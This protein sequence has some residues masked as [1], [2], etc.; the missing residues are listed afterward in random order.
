MDPYTIGALL[1]LTGPVTVAG[2]TEG[3]STELTADNVVDYLLR[4]EYRADDFQPGG[5]R[6]ERLGAAGEA[7]FDRLTS[8][9]LPPPRRLADLLSP[10]VHARR[11]LFATTDPAPHDLLERI[12]LWP[13]I[14]RGDDDTVLV[15]HGNRRANKLDAYLERA[16]SYRA[17]VADDGTVDATVR[18]ELTNTAPVTGLADYQITHTGPTDPTPATSNV[19]TLSIYSAFAETAVLVDGEPSSFNA[20]PAYGLTQYS[21]PVTVPAQSRAVVE[22]HLT[23]TVD[24]ATCSFS[25]V[26]DAGSSPDTFES[27]IVLAKA[28]R[29]VARH[30]L[31]QRVTT[32]CAA[33]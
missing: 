23:G 2:P 29:V 31:G 21:I 6:K 3:S 28:T 25:A 8:R 13:T 24:P 5:D 17:E 32:A 18:V 19:L 10:L 14:D 30:K 1:E 15:T 16:I 7:A 4:D 11:L 27:S 26:P 22:L 9:R 20:S 12:G 33:G